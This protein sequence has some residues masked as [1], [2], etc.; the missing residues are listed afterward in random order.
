[1]KRRVI[2]AAG[3]GGDDPGVGGPG[4][5]TEA[6]ECVDIVNRA[7]AKL[8]TDGRIA[9]VVVP[10]NLGLRGAIDWINARFSAH[11]D[12]Y[13]IEV[14]KNA[15][16]GNGTGVEAWYLTDDE[17]SRRKAVAVLTQLSKVT[18][19]KDR[20]AKPD[21]DN[22][23]GRLGWVRQTKPWAGLFEC[24]FIDRDHLRNDHYAEGLFRGLLEL[25]DLR[26]EALA[27]YRVIRS[28]GKQ[29][30]AFRVRSNAWRAFQSVNG[31]ARIVTR[32]GRDVTADFIDEF[33][34]PGGGVRGDAPD[35]VDTEEEVEE[36]YEPIAHGDPSIA[37]EPDELLPEADTE[38]LDPNALLEGA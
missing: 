26:D 15:A 21:K 13:C 30:G 12:G 8:R 38:E 24:G 29:I 33:G 36:G 16:N 4:G 3:H 2:L 20:G 17:S 7:A 1:M 35:D 37:E 10:H 18:R 34:G 22:R 28:D 11:D 5:R 9:V 6:A 23:H 19:L 31:E 27:I 32:E 14:H 25:F